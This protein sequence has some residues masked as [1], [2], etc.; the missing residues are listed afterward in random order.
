MEFEEGEVADVSDSEQECSPKPRRD[1]LR[2]NR[3]KH[4]RHHTKHK[5]EK[6]SHKTLRLDK[7]SSSR[8]NG[9]DVGSA[10]DPQKR[11]KK[12]IKE[13][14]SEDDEL[15][16]H[17]SERDREER[18]HDFDLRRSRKRR[19]MERFT[20]PPMQ[21]K[22]R[23]FMEGRCNKGDSCPFAHD[24]QP[25]KKQELCKFYAVGVCSKGPTCLYLHEEVPCKFYHFFGKCSHGDSCKFSHEPL[26][27]ESQALLN[28]IAGSTDQ[29]SN[30]VGSVPDSCR[31]SRDDPPYSGFGEHGDVDY[32]FGQRPA[33]F[34]NPPIGPNFGSPPRPTIGPG[35]HLRALL[36]SNHYEARDL[37]GPHPSF[38]NRHGDR[39]DRPRFPLD[40]GYRMKGPSAYP[41]SNYPPTQFPNP[42]SMGGTYPISSVGFVPGDHPM[43]LR[44]PPISNLSP[45]EI[46]FHPDFPRF[47]QSFCSPRVPLTAPMPLNP[48]IRLNNEALVSSELDKMAALLAASKPP[49]AASVLT[50]SPLDPRVQSPGNAARVEVPQSPVPLDNQI[51]IPEALDIPLRRSSLTLNS[52]ELNVVPP[53]PSLPTSPTPA[54]WRLIP[55]NMNVKIPYP[56]MQLPIDELPH[57]YEDPRLR[58]QL[59]TLRP[60]PKPTTPVDCANDVGLSAVGSKNC[61]TEDSQPP[62]EMDESN[63]PTPRRPVKL[64]LNEMASTFANYH[65]ATVANTLTKTNDRSYLD[66]PRFRRRRIVTAGACSQVPSTESSDLTTSGSVHHAAL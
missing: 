17:P 57:R 44:P 16:L 8:A 51:T 24:F 1:E 40:G 15:P 38:I 6:S 34:S 3:S 52:P 59:T 4:S 55:L 18:D 20:K 23:Y 36:P 27:P 19:K 31:P 43:R 39:M 41:D 65:P 49:P 14:L 30:T 62:E 28:R 48:A 21:A 47:R 64:Q 53:G 63:I 66:D 58:G 22:C 54:Q 5:H 29:P 37:L 32:R 26:T 10:K 25:T 13:H 56:L 60:P 2:H 42:G 12:S 11:H 50:S 9:P 33:H 46:P 35:P 7:R 61:S 45:P